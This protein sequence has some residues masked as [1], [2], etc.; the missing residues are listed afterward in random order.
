MTPQAALQRAI[1]MATT[2]PLCQKSHRGVILFHPDQEGCTLAVNG[3]PVGFKC[4]G[5]TACRAACRDVAVHAEARA[6]LGGLAHGY[7]L[8]DGWELLHVKVIDG[9]P[10]PSGPPSC[11]RCSALIVESGIPKAWLLH[12]QGLT[13]YS[14]EEFH[15]LSLR[16]HGLPG[17]RE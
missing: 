5:S 13:S 6:I 17:T 7:R 2:L 1:E 9:Q 15:A 4:D 16:Y 8:R 3:P 14:A 10:V 12:E 11:V